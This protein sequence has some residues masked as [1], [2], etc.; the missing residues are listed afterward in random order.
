MPVLQDPNRFYHPPLVRR[1]KEELRAK[2]HA[3]L[4]QFFARGGQV[5]EM[6]VEA[7]ANE[8]LRRDVTWSPSKGRLNGGGRTWSE[9]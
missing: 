9:R 6:P 4:E 8:W 7:T 1:E 3:D 2:I 5:K